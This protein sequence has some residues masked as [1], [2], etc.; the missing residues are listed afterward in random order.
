MPY[1]R[2]FNYSDECFMA[3]HSARIKQYLIVLEDIYIL[4][5]RP[6]LC[7]QNPKHSLNLFGDISSLT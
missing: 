6:S 2:V 4:L 5:N 7:K 1:S 3:L